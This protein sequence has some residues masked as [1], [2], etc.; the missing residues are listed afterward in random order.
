MAG[1]PRS[2]IIEA[3]PIRK[4][5]DAFC[6]SFN[7]ICEGAHLPCNPDALEQLGQEGLQK[8][9]LAFLSA[10][11]NL[12][13]ARLLPAATCRGALRSDLLRLELSLELDNFDLDGIK[14]L[15]RAALADNYDDALIW[16]R[17]YDAVTESTPPPRPIAS[18]I[19][20]TL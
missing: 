13:A 17:V 15:L 1:Q 19:Q 6:D 12:P 2:M 10:A 18:S 7:L 11:Q 3:N 4:G 8:L 20:Q 5:L 9:V 16:D 14:P